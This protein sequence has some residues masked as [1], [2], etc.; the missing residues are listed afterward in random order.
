VLVRAATVPDIPA[1]VAMGVRFLQDSRYSDQ[2]EAEIDIDPLVRLVEACL[3]LGTVLVLERNPQHLVG[4][5]ALLITPH[6]V[7][8]QPTAT[9][10]A[11]WVNPEDR[12]GSEGVRLLHAAEQW[13]RDQGAT[14]LHMIAPAG[15]P[16]G[17]LYERRGYA[18]LETA[19][20][21]TL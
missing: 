9:E 11:W 5:L 10:V 3:R 7:T 20:V 6:H 16:V 1:I 15:S 13:A 2:V 8:G 18:A 12:L 21:R 19:Y 14:R 17:R 4:F